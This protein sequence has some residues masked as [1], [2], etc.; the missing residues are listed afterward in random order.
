MNEKFEKPLF[1]PSTKAKVGHDVHIS[2]GEV[3]AQR[4]IDNKMMGKIENAAFSLFEFGTKHC[5]K[6]GLILVDTKYEFGLLDGELYLA[7][8]IHTPDSSRFWYADTY[9]QLLE[10]GKD[11]RMIDKEFL[12]Q[13][14]IREKNFSGDGQL[15]TIP[16]GIKVEFAKRYIRAFEE[17][18]GQKFKA[19]VGS[20]LE[21]IKENLKKGS[22]L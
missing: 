16:D 11:Q 3:L 6:Q 4:I 1:T 17:I 12:R 19:S 21:R 14:L 10:A 18:T 22:Y 5:A 15:P 7:D 8:E 20:I 13:W 2:K 9:G